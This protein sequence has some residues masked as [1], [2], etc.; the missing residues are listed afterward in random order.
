MPPPHQCLQVY[1]VIEHRVSSVYPVA[2]TLLSYQRAMSDDQTTR[3]DLSHTN[4]SH[5][6]STRKTI[7][8]VDTETHTYTL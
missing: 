5:H 3:L 4:Q 8:K 2:H 6:T 1:Q 7:F